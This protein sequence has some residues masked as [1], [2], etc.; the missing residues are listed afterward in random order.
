MERKDM[1]KNS[2]FSVVEVVIVVVIVGIVGTLGVVGY[3][4]WQQTQ[5]THDTKTNTS[6]QTASEAPEINTTGDLDKAL[7][8]LDQ[9]DVA[10]TDDSQLA[11]Q[12]NA[13]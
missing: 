2:G 3:T 5:A 13:F 9:A 7:T 11:S 1:R 12:S 6:Q 4:R 10:G 8:T